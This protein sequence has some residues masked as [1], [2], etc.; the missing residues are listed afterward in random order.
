MKGKSVKKLKYYKTAVPVYLGQTSA[1]FEREG[2]L[3]KY[4]Y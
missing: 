2:K 4:T 1:Y 3:L